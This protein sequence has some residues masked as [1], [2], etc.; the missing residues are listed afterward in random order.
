VRAWILCLT[1]GCAAGAPLPPEAAALNAAGVEALAAGDLETADARLS[2]ALEYSPHFVEA[3]VNLGLVELERGNFGRARLLCERA[4][5]LNP[6]VA[7]PH[8]A[9]G[10]LAE[11]ER[12]PDRATRHYYDALRVDPGFA[13]ARANL[14]RLLF[15]G[16][17]VEEALTQYERLVE[18]APADPDAAAGLIETLLRLGRRDEAEQRLGVARERFADAPSLVLLGARQELRAGRVAGAIAMLQPL[19]TRHD[20]LGAA[21]L[22]WLATAELA[23][24]D[25]RAAL[26]PARRA[27]ELDPE[28]TV[29]TYALALALRELG[30]PEAA[31]W[32]ARAL[33]T[34]PHD[35]LLAPAH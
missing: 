23:R 11:H 9:L 31:A 21:A 18:V 19:S 29:A 1:T 20:E 12:R 34:S 7:Q 28:S 16:G 25:A 32:V 6:D 5:R 13:P 3:L 15:K 8:H 10:V 24:G 14:A 22:G 17:L 4:R 33:R 35:P 26:V 2:V 30:S 27:L